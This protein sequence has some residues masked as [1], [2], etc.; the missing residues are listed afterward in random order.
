MGNLS[1][2]K[3]FGERPPAR[4]TGRGKPLLTPRS[5]L[6]DE[7]PRARL[8]ILSLLFLGSVLVFFPGIGEITGVTAKDEYILIHRTALTMLERSEWVVPYLDGVPRIRKP[9]MVPWLTRLSFEILG[10]SLTSVRIVSVLFAG[11]FVVVVALI[12][13]EITRNFNYGLS[14]AL[15]ALSTAG[16]AVQSRFSMLDIPT[17]A[18]SG[19]GF[20]WFLRWCKRPCALL[21]VGVAVALACG[22]LTKGP[23]VG[24]LFGSGLA[25]LMLTS[26]EAR[27]LI[28]FRRKKSLLGLVVLF[29][30]LS[31]AWYAYAYWK[32]PNETAASLESEALELHLGNLTLQPIAAAAVLAFPWTFLVFGALVRLKD[33]ARGESELWIYRARTFFLL[34]TGLSLLP[35]LFM[36]AFERYIMGSLIP[37]SL[38]CAAWF[39][40]TASAPIRVWS[41]LGALA[42]TFSV[43]AAAG[44]SWW[45]TTAFVELLLL[46]A[47]YVFF[48]LV[49]WRGVGAL[50]MA[51]SAAM[52]WTALIGVLY[53][54]FGANAIPA[55]IVEKTRAEKVYLYSEIHALLSITL[56]RSLERVNRI[57]SLRPSGPQKGCPL[58][59]VTE[60]DRAR[61]EQGLQSLG[62]G[63]K[64]VASYKTLRQIED[65]MKGVFS[66]EIRSQWRTALRT[67][68]LEPIKDTIFLYRLDIPGMCETDSAIPHRPAQ[69]PGPDARTSGEL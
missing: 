59:F 52:L 46:S 26:R 32:Y 13:C 65:V 56:G 25:A 55:D 21:L 42:T 10:V 64:P 34:W 39:G 24:V 28:F 20:Y 53:P 7:N 43:L 45:F 49:W 66:G 31:L 57:Q 23:V 2:S 47:A 50:R 68:S 36:T 48:A 44:F 58:I 40:S 35:F 33:T 11:F 27:A 29:L 30:G 3:D 1:G 62:A 61:F 60:R 15:I 8:L 54:T 6:P 37:I 14:A 69:E 9:P 18:F 67:R 17:A 19:L 4:P 51:I 5:Y 22:F 63:A 12:G 16:L 41:R 38:I